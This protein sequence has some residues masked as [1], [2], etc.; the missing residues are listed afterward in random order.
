MVTV[1]PP[2]PE[3]GCLSEGAQVPPE[4]SAIAR[5]GSACLAC[6][7]DL[8]QGRSAPQPAALPDPE[9]GCSWGCL[10]TD[11]NEPAMANLEGDDPP[12][13]SGGG[14]TSGQAADPPQTLRRTAKGP[15]RGSAILENRRTPHTPVR[16]FRSRHR[17]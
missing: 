13:S 16:M 17:A 7:R 3:L 4:C 6:R 2:T 1:E 14:G 9:M 5:A 12:P 11:R 15:V 10:K 8:D